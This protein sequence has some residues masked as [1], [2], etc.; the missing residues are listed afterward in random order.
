M[1][2]LTSCFKTTSRSPR[3]CGACSKTEGLWPSTRVGVVSLFT[4]AVNHRAEPGW[5]ICDDLPY[6]AHGAQA[7]LFPPDAAKAFLSIGPVR[8][9][10][11][12]EDYW[13]GW[14]CRHTNREY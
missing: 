7:Y 2:T 14:W 11:T 5:H 4:A 9:T 10:W 3:I 8:N 12:H 1:H 13:V 6:G